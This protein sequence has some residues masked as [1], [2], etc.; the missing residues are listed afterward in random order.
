MVRTALVATVLAYAGVI[1]EANNN[2]HV[3][4][5]NPCPGE[6]FQVLL[7]VCPAQVGTFTGG[8]TF[9]LE[10][11]AVPGELEA[12]L[13]E[14]GVLYEVGNRKIWHLRA[15][16]NPGLVKLTATATVDQDPDYTLTYTAI[17]RV[18]A[19]PGSSCSSCASTE[20]ERIAI[21]DGPE[22]EFPLG[23]QRL[24]DNDEVVDANM[25]PIPVSLI[26]PRG[27]AENLL[28]DPNELI[29]MHPY[30][31]F[32]DTGGNPQ[33]NVFRC[34]G[35][36]VNGCSLVV[37]LGNYFGESGRRIRRAAIVTRLE[38]GYRISLI[39]TSGADD[40]Q[41]CCPTWLDQPEP[42]LEWVVEETD[43][44]EV[45]VTRF[46]NGEDDHVTRLNY[47]A[48]AGGGDEWIMKS[49]ENTSN[50]VRQESV[51]WKNEGDWLRTRKIE[52]VHASNWY[53]AESSYTIHEERGGPW[54]TR[55]A[56]P[57]G[58]DPQVTERAYHGNGEL[59]YEISPDGNWRWHEYG[60]DEN[61][62]E[63]ITTY[64][65]WMDDAKPSS[66][67]EW[68]SYRKTTM[69]DAYAPTGIRRL[70]AVEETYVDGNLFAKTG[71]AVSGSNPYTETRET[72]FNSTDGL[73]TVTSGIEVPDDQAIPL[74]ALKWTGRASPDA[75]S[76]TWTGEW[77]QTG[78]SFTGLTP[79]LGLGTTHVYRESVESA[80][81]GQSITVTEVND[82]EGRNVFRR[83]ELGVGENRELIEWTAHDFDLL[84]RPILTVNSNGT[85]VATQYYDC[86]HKRAITSSDGSIVQQVFDAAGRPV[87][88]AR[89]AN[90]VRLITKYTYQSFSYGGGTLPGVIVE[91]GFDEEEP[92]EAVGSITVQ[93][94]TRTIYD[95][96]GRVVSEA[97]LDGS[98]VEL[99]T[100]Y[101]YSH[102][103]QGG[104]VVTMTRPDS[105]T[106]IRSY[107]CDGRLK[108]VTGTGVVQTTYDYSVDEHVEGAENAVLTVIRQTGSESPRETRES[109]D[110]MNRLVG[111]SRAGWAAEGSVEIR[112]LHAY[113][114]D[115]VAGAGQVASIEEFA[116]SE[117]TRGATRFE[118]ARAD[119]EEIIR[120]GI[121]LSGSGSLDEEIDRYTETRASYQEVL[122]GLAHV[123]EERATDGEGLVLV[124]TTQRAVGDTV[125][126]PPDGTGEHVRSWVRVIGEDADDISDSVQSEGP[127][128]NQ[129][130]STRV[131][132]DVNWATTASNAGRVVSRISASEVETTYVYD[133]MR[134]QQVE[135]AGRKTEYEY[136]L[137]G[138]MTEQREG[139]PLGT[140]SVTQYDYY[141]QNEPGGGQVKWIKNHDDK[142]TRYAY[143]EFGRQTH[144]WGDVPQPTWSEYDQ[145]GQRTKLHTYRTGDF[146]G[147]SW[148]G[149]AGDGDVT[150]WVYHGPTGLLSSKVYAD[151]KST[152]YEYKPDGRLW[153]RI[154]VREIDSARVTTTYGYHETTG[155]LET[156]DY[157]DDTPD[158][159]YTYDRRGRIDTVTQGDDWLI[160]DLDHDGAA[161][162][163]S[164]AVSGDI[165]EYAL[166]RTMAPEFGGPVSAVEVEADSSPIYAAAYAYDTETDTARLTRVT[167]PG[168]PTGGGS[169]H[170]VFYGYA[171]DTD[172][173]GTIEVRADGGGV[174]LRTTRAYDADRELIDSIENT[175][176]PDGT[177]A[178]ISK[179]DY[180]NDSLARRSAVVNTGIAFA[181]SAYNRYGYNDRSE[182]TA[183][184]RYFG[185]DPGEWETSDPVDN[186]HFTYAYDPIGNRTDA[187]RGQ[188]KP[189]EVIYDGNQ[190]N[191]YDQTRS[192]E[193]VFSTNLTYD[194]D[195]NLT[196]EWLDGDCN[197]DGQVNVGDIN[198]FNLALSDASEYEMTYP[199]C[200]LVTADANNDGDVDVLD[201]NPFVDLLLGGGSGGR[202]LVWDA[203]NRLAAVRPAVEDEDLPDEAL[204]S[205][206]AYDYLN[207]RVMK[208]V[209]E[210]D[211]GE[212]EWTLVLD[213]RYVYDGWR[214]LL[215]LDGLNSNA[216]IR[217]YT[218]GLDLAGLGGAVNDRVSA[219]GIGGLLAV[220]DTNGTT[221]GANPEADDLKY[222]YTYDA[223]GNVGQL[224]DPAAGSAAS[225]IKAHYEY[226]PYG[227]V[228][229][230]SGTYAAT[231][232]YRFSTKLWDDETGLGYWGYR[233][234][235][236]RLGRWI[237]R[238][239]IGEAGGVNLFA[240]VENE[241]VT[242]VDALGLFILLSGCR[243]KEDTPAGPMP[244][245][246][247]ECCADAKAAGLDRL[248]AGGVICCDG[249]KVACA[250]YSSSGNPAED[251]VT[252]ILIRC[253][254]EHEQT[255]FDDIPDC[256]DQVPHLD[257]PDFREGVDEDKEECIGYKKA[258]ECLSREM[259]TCDKAPDPKSCR[260]R[261]EA[262]LKSIEEQIKRHCGG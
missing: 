190:L 105:E 2:F 147:S 151:D 90:G 217:K 230:S 262:K 19:S 37:Y 107:Y 15:G 148:P 154:W 41:G 174:K 259:R 71:R 150:Q 82:W 187:S 6:D 163:E 25:P 111:E 32:T 45:T 146:T 241:C 161:S 206:F 1:A 62:N 257:R 220:Y 21:D 127:D 200:T 55:V 253:T 8:P 172:L 39:E 44:H 102:T 43:E 108:S 78:F 235:D 20:N 234:N 56:D 16:H 229:A 13:E 169:T 162:T 34:P 216:I 68:T 99:E 182:L 223:N 237:S 153:K 52:L 208:R 66:I 58:D 179:Y 152:D 246:S 46:V 250:W 122:D 137:L 252:D 261:I 121:K 53:T 9:N 156:V 167:G 36:A 29:L 12:S 11:E 176:D 139:D 222:V 126:E 98:S 196:G 49:G 168:L 221:T 145:F 7:E 50:F 210:W 244:R 128:A 31:Q 195:G 181:A 231:N 33:H 202:R 175:W 106:E 28:T 177:P 26:M 61:D 73:T 260:S 240:Y 84:G 219:G 212:D 87:S 140:P 35:A 165:L 74:S 143:D 159:A 166:T 247:A 170:G 40:Y 242:Q 155:D 92:G 77:L 51:C 125:H 83:R 136:D 86:C 85:W 180:S 67:E 201:I 59:K 224:I 256:P 157:S 192:D 109:Y 239:P 123:T 144:T 48:C 248:N 185:E 197:C 160:H 149:G 238:D 54:S 188:E 114:G 199:G 100:T 207:R 214:V 138:R 103:G 94:R 171:S 198:A 38:A 104:R 205:E 69:G 183:A 236:P 30:P 130:S 191:Q 112:T 17:I 164:E 186:E 189:V 194:E 42:F 142:Y 141:D 255:H 96:A 135:H 226:D 211:T 18:G 64:F 184:R 158:V 118:Y 75:R 4:N 5:V 95:L 117:P 88:V 173:V 3:S 119:G 225:S 60:E 227:G 89:S 80:T 258:R 243:A 124:R 23:H 22:F 178:V 133:G 10:P 203:E 228:V 24:P 120:R 47:A 101:A 93:E 134:L 232:T 251:F 76:T 116:D 97:R 193:A 218:W 79:A 113:V 245:D 233:Y 63:V 27:T 204:R 115:G 209:Y 129:Y 57:D 72:F 131:N 215:E 132:P 14:I 249:K 81:G 91:S 110:M 70:P 254:T 65:G 213:R